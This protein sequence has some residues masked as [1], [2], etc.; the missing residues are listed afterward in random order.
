LR[1]AVAL[2]LSLI[3]RVMMRLSLPRS[4]INGRIGNGTMA[5][6]PS[7]EALAFSTGI[8]V[9]ASGQKESKRVSKRRN[10]RRQMI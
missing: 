4:D 8:D 3:E 9:S 6:S 1:D 7:L 10:V 2:E 5:S